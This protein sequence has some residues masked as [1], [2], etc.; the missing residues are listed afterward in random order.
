MSPTKEIPEKLAQATGNL[1]FAPTCLSRWRE[2]GFSVLCFPGILNK[3][4]RNAAQKYRV[5][6][7]S[8]TDELLSVWMSKVTPI[9]WACPSIDTTLVLFL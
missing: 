3:P 8:G 1:T 6:A 4:T 2:I 5:N 7:L 9:M